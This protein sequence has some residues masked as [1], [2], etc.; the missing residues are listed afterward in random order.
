MPWYLGHWTPC[1]LC[2]CSPVPSSSPTPCSSSPPPPLGSPSISYSLAPPSSSVLLR[3]FLPW[4]NI[5]RNPLSMTLKMNIKPAIVPA[6]ILSLHVFIAK[7]SLS[8]PTL[9]YHLLICLLISQIFVQLPFAK[10][11]AGN[12]S[13]NYEQKLTPCSHGV[14]QY[15]FIIHYLVFFFLYWKGGYTGV[16]TLSSLLPRTSLV[17]G[18]C[19]A[20]SRRS[21]GICWMN[22]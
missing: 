18:T 19:Q 20:Q 10:P 9:P 11:C 12:W 16:K 22:G 5:P 21:L 2:P 8:L 15:L 14:H 3:G 1:E 7:C 17:L 4:D 13:Y 6:N